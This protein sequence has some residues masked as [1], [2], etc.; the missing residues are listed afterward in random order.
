MASGAGVI[1]YIRNNILLVPPSD[2]WLQDKSLK[3]LGKIIFLEKINIFEE[4]YTNMKNLNKC[5]PI[6]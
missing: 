4:N 5:S 6:C 3:F 2:Y 1:V